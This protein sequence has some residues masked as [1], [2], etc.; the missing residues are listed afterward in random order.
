[1]I[2]FNQY[3]VNLLTLT[4][5]WLKLN[6]DTVCNN[7]ITYYNYKLTIIELNYKIHDKKLLVIINSFKQW[8]MY[9][10]EFKH[11]I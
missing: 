5:N 3:A 10:K 4:V 6:S 2:N 9:L 8:R 11:Q 7:F 1:M